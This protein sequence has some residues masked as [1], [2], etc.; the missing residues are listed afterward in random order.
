MKKLKKQKLT[1]LTYKTLNSYETYSFSFYSYLSYFSFYHCGKGRN[2]RWSTLRMWWF[3]IACKVRATWTSRSSC[4]GSP[5]IDPSP[6]LELNLL[7]L[8]ILMYII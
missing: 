4:I 2:I 1:Y 7:A 3:E 8:N 5:V 6:R